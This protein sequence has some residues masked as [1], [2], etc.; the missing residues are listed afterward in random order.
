[1]NK[2]ALLPLLSLIG[3]PACSTIIDGHTQE[4]N[5]NTSP[6]GAS[7]VLT[8]ENQKIA[9]VESTPQVVMVSKI[10]KPIEIT[11]HKA[12]NYN[13]NDEKAAGWDGWTWGNLLFGGLIGFGVDAG[14]GDWNKYP[15]S[16]T[17]P[18]IP[19]ESSMQQGPQPLTM[20]YQVSQPQKKQ[21]QASQIQAKP[22]DKAKAVSYDPNQ[23]PVE[24]PPISDDE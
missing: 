15:T 14:T 19:M 8:R 3:L 13:G 2:Y 7:C 21:A 18:L 23:P 22:A 10:N 17:V 20:Q 24:P 11:C 9:I 4:I 6:Q 16:V 5:I 12:P 1:M